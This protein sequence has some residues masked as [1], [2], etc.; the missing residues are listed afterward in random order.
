MIE[1]KKTTSLLQ[2][3]KLIVDTQQ[4]MSV[5]R[6]EN[7]N[8]F[9][10]LKMERKEN[11]THSAFLEELLNPN[12]THLMGNVFLRLFLEEITYKHIAYFDMES[13]ETQVEYH[14]SKRDNTTKEGGRIDILIK[15]K[16]NLTISIEN[17]IDA[18]DQEHQI[19]RY[20]NYNK[21]KNTVYYLTKYGTPASTY[22]KGALIENEAYFCISYKDTIKNWLENCLKEATNQPILRESIKQYIVLIRKITNTMENTLEKQLNKL[23]MSNYAEAAYISSNFESLKDYIKD[24][25]RNKIIE[26]TNLK[27]SDKSL[28][29]RVEN[30]SKVTSKYAQIWIKK[31]AHD[32]YYGVESF[33]GNGHHDGKLFVG[34]YVM[35]TQGLPNNTDLKSGWNKTAYILDESEEEINFSTP[36]LLSK[37]YTDKDYK[38]TLANTVAE[39]I[40]NYINTH[41]IY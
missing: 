27:I 24:S 41:P 37:L 2:Q 15:D 32:F 12:G 29:Y 1:V 19:E 40:I 23:M 30:G 25:T 10:I 9:S 5:L 14:I 16:N 18:G 21:N 6:G 13:A 34:I 33:S 28:G 7:F 17:K 20:T 22:S 39:Q 4:K 31:G 3:T 35:N 11:E 26:V 38:S 8:V 36:S